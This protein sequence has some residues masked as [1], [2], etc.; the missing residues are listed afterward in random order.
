MILVSA[1]VV[2]EVNERNEVFLGRIV[3]NTLEYTN[4]EINNVNVVG[5]VC[6]NSDCSTIENYLW[7][8]DILNTGGNNR[9][10]LVYPTELQ[11]EYGYGVY[12][13]REGYIPSE[14]LAI[15][16]GTGTTPETGYYENY[17]YR[18]DVCLANI[19][20]VNVDP[21]VFTEGEIVSIDVTVDAPL[22]ASGPLDYV[23]T[24][25]ED[26]YQT[27]V[28]VTIEIT[29]YF[30]NVVYTETR[31]TDIAFG[32]DTTLDFDWVTIA[33]D[34]RV[35]VSTDVSDSQ[36]MSS[37]VDTSIN[38]F[39]VN[40][41]GTTNNNPVLNIPDQIVDEG[42]TLNLDLDNFAN[43]IDGDSLSYTLISGEGNII[44]DSY[45]YNAPQD[46]NF[47][48][49]SY[50]IVINVSDGNNG[51]DTDSFVVNVIDDDTSGTTNNNPIITNFNA[52]VTNG[53][54]PLSVNFIGGV[55]DI[56]G[57][58][59]TCEINFGD[60]SLSEI[61]ND[62][63]NFNLNHTYV[64]SGLF[65]AELNVSDGN[66]GFDL[67]TINIDTTGS[68]SLW[69]S[70]IRFVN[71]TTSAGYHS[72]TNIIANV[73]ANETDLI[74]VIIYL[75]DSAG[76]LIGNVIDTNNIVFENFTGISEGRYYLNA[77]AEYSTGV[78]NITETREIIID[79]TEPFVEL[80]FPD[81]EDLI[82]DS[83]VDFE[84]RASDNYEIDIC[85][86]M[87]DGAIAQSNT[88]VEQGV[89]Q[90][91]SISLS[92]GEY[93]WRIDCY[94]MAGNLNS[95]ET[96]TIEVEDDD[97]G[98]SIDTGRI[99]SVIPM[100]GSIDEGYIQPITLEG[101][102]DKVFSFEWNWGL[103]LFFLLLAILILLLLIW[104]VKRNN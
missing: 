22:I 44:G 63:S 52:N 26:Y 85:Y 41:T 38:N 64:L 36:C 7:N 40:P 23:P 86:L 95:S 45:T 69:D 74:E 92:N 81:D 65:T 76:T 58:I 80:I 73:S 20:G 9:I 13:F 101:V 5:V 96:R 10:T 98:G 75:Y 88:A 6:G 24:E 12:Y 84:Y 89:T 99:A 79:L 66:N 37:I 25:L 27:D 17:L 33:G 32:E 91:F 50:V 77:S 55:N 68:S 78:I 11:S 104:L 15:G 56:D 57:D 87:I 30:G 16:Q 93:D 67:Q 18:K 29:D 35:L 100:G 97:N 60:G 42:D 21:G 47:D 59:L 4:Q 72:Q 39:H 61:I 31:N 103:F 34:Y 14:V 48:N 83:R 51:F 62:C 28:E 2:A 71:P 53:D 1:F 54:A 94:D 49:E 3:D 46:S 8:G 43:D 90:E 102:M 19:D 70:L 82:E